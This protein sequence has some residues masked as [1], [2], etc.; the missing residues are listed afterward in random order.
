MAARHGRDHGV[1]DCDQD[2]TNTQEHRGDRQA[3]CRARLGC[4]LAHRYWAA[5]IH[6]PTCVYSASLLSQVQRKIEE[7]GAVV[8][9]L[10]NAEDHAAVRDAAA[11]GTLSI[12]GTAVTLLK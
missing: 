9:Q 3:A 10:F 11:E 6:H 5:F 8:V 2:Q 4:R 12:F 1:P 7:Y